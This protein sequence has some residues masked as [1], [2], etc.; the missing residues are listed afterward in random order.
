MDFSFSEEQQMLQESVQKF[1]H[2]NYDFE[3]RKGII[4]D[5]RGYS[6]AN[7]SLFAEL[8]W[9]TVPFTEAD[10]GFGGSAVDL[11]VMMEEFGKGMVVEPFVATAVLSGSVVAGLGDA[12]QKGD[13]LAQVMAG[14]IQLA[15][16]FSEPQSRYQLANV[17]TTAT[18]GSGKLLLNGRKINVL[19]GAHADRLLVVARESGKQCD[20]AG[21]SVFLVDPASPGISRQA[22]RNV[23]G[24]SAANIEFNNVE[25][26]ASDRLG[27]AGAALPVLEQAVDRA[28]LAIA[29]EAVG[30][31]ECLLR[32]TVEYAKTRKQFGVPIGSFQALQH[33]MAD[34]FIECQLAR[35]IVM[36]AAMRLDSSADAKAK[37]AAV[38]AA[39]S[40]VGRAIRKVS[41]E[42]VQIHGGIGITEELDVAHY[43]KR[44]TAIEVQ[45]GNSE[46]HTARFIAL[47]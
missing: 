29:A 4:A 38:S 21:I 7:W 12:A 36:M 6:T 26:A 20:E 42:A 47:Q 17:A 13:L 27:K 22:F 11:M 2:K 5:P 40:R 28:T 14:E 30:A 23:D 45:F 15:C 43:F 44:V 39:K 34:M 8:G 19:N 24:Q 46:Y 10:G 9:L 31:L 41:R 32:K 25:I 18:A 35:S 3:T 37:A 33:R 16:A 1:V